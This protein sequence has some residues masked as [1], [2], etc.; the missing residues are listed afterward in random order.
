M[1]EDLLLGSS[2]KN[3]RRAGGPMSRRGS[4]AIDSFYALN[5]AISRR[6]IPSIA[7]STPPAHGSATVNGMNVVYTPAGNFF[8][9]DSSSMSP[10]EPVG[11]RRRRP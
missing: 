5:A 9:S 3:G 7:I 6:P 4:A 8:S 2:I 1:R 11:R 10:P